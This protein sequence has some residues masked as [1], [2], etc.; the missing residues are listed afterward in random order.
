MTTIIKNRQAVADDYTLLTL[1]EGDSAETVA[2]PAGPLLV[3]LAVWQVRKADL[4]SRGTPVGV[5]LAAGEG[6]EAIADDL[7][8][9]PVVGVHFPK[10]VDGRGYS[11]ARLLRERHG[12]QGEIRALGDVLHDQLFLMARCGF[13]AFA[14]KEGK[15]IAKAVA[16][17]ET[18]KNPYQAAVD[19]P[20]PLFR[21][22]A[23]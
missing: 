2:L 19:Q 6:P 22:R 16:A 1:A 8:A 3:P 14:L 13:D 20:Q 4:Q 9:L 15:D 21:R 18:F 7:A 10:F 17:F 11:T 5:W 23:A 12:Y